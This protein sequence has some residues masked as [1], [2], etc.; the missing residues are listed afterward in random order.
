M[1]KYPQHKASNP[2]SHP[3]NKPS[4]SD[5]ELFQIFTNFSCLVEPPMPGHSIHKFPHRTKSNQTYHPPKHKQNKHDKIHTKH[6]RTNA[7]EETESSDP[8]SSEERDGDD[9]VNHIEEP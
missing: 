1:N 2:P 3:P 4:Y 8:E 9:Q 7:I 6:V 5:Y